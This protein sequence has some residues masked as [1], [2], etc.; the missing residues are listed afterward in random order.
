M[1]HHLM[2]ATPAGRELMNGAF[3]CATIHY[4]DITTTDL[5]FSACEC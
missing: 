4:I 1:C 3:S 5:L 2:L